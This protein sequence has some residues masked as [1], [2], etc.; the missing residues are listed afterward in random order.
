[1]PDIA[2]LLAADVLAVIQRMEDTEDGEDF[3]PD[4]IAELMSLAADLASHHI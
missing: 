1:M 3:E 2:K 4:D